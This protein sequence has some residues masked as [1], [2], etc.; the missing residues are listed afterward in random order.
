MKKYGLT[1]FQIITRNIFISAIC[2]G[3]F[4]FEAQLFGLAV[5]FYVAGAVG[6]VVAQIAFFLIFAGKDNEDKD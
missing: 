2:F 4:G 5:P 3:L 1:T 6:V